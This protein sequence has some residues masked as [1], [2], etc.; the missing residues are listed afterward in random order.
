[1]N[2]LRNRVSD[3]EPTSTIL[4]KSSDLRKLSFLSARTRVP[5]N[6]LQS[7]L[8]PDRMALALS[9]HIILRNTLPSLEPC[10]RQAAYV[11]RVSR[12]VKDFFG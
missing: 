1:M 6:R 7:E 8:P 12:A 3:T 5:A 4:A 2:R 10:D 11:E 9:D